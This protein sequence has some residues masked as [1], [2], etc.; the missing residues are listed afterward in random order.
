VESHQEPA[1]VMTIAWAS[2]TAVMMH[3]QSVV[4]VKRWNP[5]A[6][7][8]G[9]VTEQHLQVAPVVQIVSLPGH[10]ARM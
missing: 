7:V 2:A 6:V 9:S 1:G 3:V 5:L 8:K 10:A 4:F